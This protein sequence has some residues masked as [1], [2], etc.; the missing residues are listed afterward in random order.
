MDQQQVAS[1]YY[2]PLIQTIKDN[3]RWTISEEKRPLDLVKILNPQT[4]QTS[5]LPGATYRDARCLVTLDTL[6][7]HFTTPPNITYFLDTALDDF[8]VIDIEKH[9]P[10]NLKQQL[11]Q[12]PH[13]YA[14]YSSSGTGI[15]LIVRKP[16]NYYDYPNALEKP[17]LQFRDPTPPPPP[18]QP[19]VWFEILQH[20]FV[21]FTGNQVLF[22][23][24]QQPLEP[25][26]QELAQNA[27]KVVRGDIET[28]M[29]L[30]IEDI[31]DGQWIVDQ[32]TGF[33]PTKDRSEYHLQSHYD[34]ATIGVIRHQWKKLQSSMKIK[35]NGHKYTE[36]E[37]VL[38]LYHA[39]SKT[40]PWRDK[41]GESRL[42][43][44]YLMYAITNQLAEDKGKQEEKRRRKEGEH[45]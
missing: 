34:Y 9:C 1:L 28:D 40:L 6:V 15:H 4:Q 20:H 30:S 12:I 11:L 25:F 35:L 38:L 45:K 22:P 17:S 42:G 14:E 5:H 13:L 8:L 29:D 31:P 39:V 33:T 10:E 26:Y 37:E 43:M 2:H 41:Y 44:P 18:E 27:K 32:L 16:S 23:Q 3:P 7:S 36:A 21:K 19:K 24:G